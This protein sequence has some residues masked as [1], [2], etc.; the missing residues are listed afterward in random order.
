M[1]TQPLQPRRFRQP[2]INASPVAR[3]LAQRHDLDLRSVSGSGPAGR[4]VKSDL[5]AMLQA[6]PTQEKA[7]TAFPTP[8]SDPS[9]T[10]PVSADPP[11][12]PGMQGPWVNIP[13]VADKIAGMR[14][15]IARRLTEAKQQIPHI[16][17]TLDVRVDPLLAL[18]QQLNASLEG[19]AIKLSVNDMLI[20]ALALALK[21]VP[22]CNVMISGDHLL[23]FQ[24]A[25]ISV[26]VSVPNGL[27]TPV[28]I[29]ADGK[30]LSTIAVEAQNLARRA[31][32]GKLTPDQYQGGTA[33]LS[34]LGMFGIKQ[35]DA[36]INPPQSA[37]LAIGAAEKRPY[38]IDGELSV[39]TVLTATGSF[40]HRA[41]DG[42]A[43]A[44]L[45]SALKSL[46]ENPL[47]L[48]A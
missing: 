40:D 2:R 6:A 14:K 48:L 7:V 46:I 38:V 29:D 20:K 43:G 12:R 22:E 11:E 39:A 31:R 28:I 35:F 4:I 10:V 30:S 15:T 26:A 24:R 9:L 17:L 18:R 42:A 16:Y 32:E 23:S 41:I 3:R 36:I 45:M 21:E 13:H 5:D 47:A 33:S 19:R 27:L 1:L 34:N 8:S 44:Q 37:I 25:D